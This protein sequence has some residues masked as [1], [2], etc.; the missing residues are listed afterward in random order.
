M[1]SPAYAPP[2]ESASDL[3]LERSNFA[4]VFVGGVAY[5]NTC[6][7]AQLDYVLI[8]DLFLGIHVA[9]FAAATYFIISAYQASKRLPWSFRTFIFALFTLGTIDIA[10]NTKFGEMMW[11]DDRNIPGGPNAWLEAG[12]STP[13]NVLGNASYI[14]S[15]F[16]ADAMIVRSLH[17]AYGCTADIWSR[18]IVSGSSGATIGTSS[19]FRYCLS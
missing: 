7:P 9:V 16:L 12:Y 18:Y 6:L 3:W 13:V 19:S 14:F 2:G 10:C 15:N 17:A 8:T 11:I 1:S 5:G 4:G